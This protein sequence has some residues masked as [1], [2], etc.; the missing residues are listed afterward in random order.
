MFCVLFR[1]LLVDGVAH[2]VV[3]PYY[4]DHYR[5]DDDQDVPQVARHLDPSMQQKVNKLVYHRQVLPSNNISNV[6]LRD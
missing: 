1:D 3:G 6:N 2:V 4:A 5:Q